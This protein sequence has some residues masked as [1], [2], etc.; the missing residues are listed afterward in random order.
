MCIL[1][2]SAKKIGSLLVFCKYVLKPLRAIV[3]TLIVGFSIYK[4]VHIW[5]KRADGFT[6]ENIH[7]NHP[8]NPNWEVHAT[9]ADIEQANEILKQPFH[10]LGRGFQCYAFESEDGKYVL[11]FIRHQRLRL[12][13]FLKTLP[14]IGAF[15]KIKEKKRA[16]FEKRSRYLFN[17]LKVGF[18]HA[19]DETALIFVHLNKTENQHGKV[20]ITDKENTAYEI[21]LNAVEFILQRKAVHIKP[22]LEKLMADGKV[23]EAEKRIDQIFD[24]LVHC[25]KRGILDTDGALIRKNNLGFLDDHAIYI[26]TGKL[27][28]KEDIKRKDRFVKDLKRL[29]L[30]EKWLGEKYPVLRDYFVE[31]KKSVIQGF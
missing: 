6:V 19:R 28:V 1:H 18:D 14:D 10:Y 21:D 11:K 29:Y 26:D 31:K 8:F 30:L 9:K 2:R 12:S 22:T 23:A 24:L 13:N 16:D 7:S 27:Q 5:D 4:A 20:K 15:K 3:F 25:A 17:G